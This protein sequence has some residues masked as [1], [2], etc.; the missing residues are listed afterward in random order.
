M[1]VSHNEHS[2]KLSLF[3]GG[4]R[5]GKSLLAENFIL[6]STKKPVYL[7]TAE[8]RDQEMR[9]RADIHAQRRNDNWRLIEEPIDLVNAISAISDD[10]I[11]LID[12]LTLWLSNL[13][14]IGSDL[15]LEHSKLL[16]AVGNCRGSVVC[17]SNEVGMGIV[18]EYAIAR[19]FRDA[20]GTLNQRVAAQ[21]GL[22]VFVAAG[23]PLVIKG[24]I[25][26]D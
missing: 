12:C 26:N 14:A 6:A 10:E 4:A 11:V 21:A 23:L 20:Q 2:P 24:G 7:A 22:V 5:S 15:R 16:S 13:M 17:V 19:E 1:I 18:P 3:L 25:P 8:I 9:I